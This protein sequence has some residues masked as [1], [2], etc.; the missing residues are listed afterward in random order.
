MKKKGKNLIIMTL[1]LALL[2]G[3][4]FTWRAV[5]GTGEGSG[6]DSDTAEGSYSVGTV[7]HQTLT[8]VSVTRL[9]AQDG[10]DGTS[11]QTVRFDFTLKEDETGWLWSED[12]NVPL[13]NEKFADMATAVSAITSPYKL[14]NVSAD[15]LTKYG[16]DSP[17]ISLSFTDGSGTH[18]F[19]IGKTN[20]FDGSNYFC[21]DDKTTVYTVSASVA[22][23]F[24]FDIFDIIK[25]DTAPA[26]NASA[27]TSLEYTCKDRTLLFTYY[28][29]GKES[30]YTGKYNWYVSENGGAETAVA[31]DIG[32]ALTEALT[33]IDLGNCVAYDRKSDK[34]FGLDSGARLVLKYQKTTK[35]TDSGTN[36]E[37]E[38][39]TPAE[40]VLNI[41]VSDDG[42]VYA[43]PDGSPLVAKL[44]H[45]SAFSS[46]TA[47]NT[48]V[49]R[50]NELVL[51]DYSRIDSMVFTADGK[52][53]TV[54]VEHGED[55]GISYS[56]SGDG[57]P[58]NETL[59]ALLGAL[60][61]AR[62]TAF[63][64]DLDRDPAS[65]SDTV[66]SVAFAFNTGDNLNATLTLSR[67]SENYYLVS[68]MSDG[69]RLITAD[70]LKALTD[71]FDACV[72]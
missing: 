65:G 25:T 69:D 21:T 20:S 18:R 54:K 53:M 56:V 41:G 6:T 3:A 48:R 13:D 46:I 67:Y 66:F 39:T 51:P 2:T 7:D 38:V 30:S 31:F 71:A 1:I 49:L 12:K 35:I 70:G 32:N 33:A 27:I 16:L 24:R 9:E 42:T 43:V 44:S 52:T 29:D 14:E 72:K 45:Q 22:E 11:G 26:I 59:E 68:F 28:P 50:A 23:A 36:V 8:A 4:Y 63:A 61:D 15:D 64:S 19:Y 57:T 58:D 62:T 37:K 60:A 17:Q 47:D 55:G 40:Y 5:G 34:T 10:A